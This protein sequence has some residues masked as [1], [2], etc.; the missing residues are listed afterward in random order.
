MDGDLETAQYFYDKARQANDADG[1]VGLATER[2][3]EGKK[4]VTVAAG[5]SRQVDG[6]LDRYSEQRHQ[7]TGPIELTPRGN[8]SEGNSSAAPADP[9]SSDVPPTTVP[10]VPQLQ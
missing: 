9:S 3:A 6:Q 2:V 1:R 8:T 4:L 10:P 7:E 5:S